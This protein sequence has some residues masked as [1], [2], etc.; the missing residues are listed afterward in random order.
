MLLVFEWC[1]RLD[2][3]IDVDD[4]DGVYGTERDGMKWVSCAR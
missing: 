3:V 4:F 1:G 2:G